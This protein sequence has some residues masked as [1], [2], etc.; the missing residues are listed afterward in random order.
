M[1]KKKKEIPIK[2]N[3]TFP[4]ATSFTFLSRRQ[5]ISEQI[6]SFCCNGNELAVVLD[7]EE[8]RDP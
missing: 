7:V 2:I 8:R 1:V 6:T 3:I 4:V 5:T